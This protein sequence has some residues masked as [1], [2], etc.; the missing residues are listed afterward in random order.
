MRRVVR[1]LFTSLLLASA[2]ATSS[3]REETTTAG[4][5]SAQPSG[6]AST[7]TQPEASTQPASIVT[8]PL[9]PVRGG[10]RVLP[11]YKGPEPCRMALLGTSPVAKA[12]SEGGQRRAVELMSL[13]VK[14]ARA[15]GIVFECTD[16]HASEDDLSQLK[17]HAELEFR[18]L[19]FLAR[20]PD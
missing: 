9:E 4:E 10:A 6:G 15:E 20:P 18:K 11:P 13:F 12:C 14:R 8:E 19:L 5:A 17:P 7:A 1:L 2:C 16:C 3:P